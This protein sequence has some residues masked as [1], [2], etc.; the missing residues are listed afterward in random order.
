MSFERACMCEASPK[1]VT[2]LDVT[3]TSRIA[4]KSGPPPP[5]WNDRTVIP[6]RWRLSLASSMRDSAPPMPLLEL[7]TQFHSLNVWAVNL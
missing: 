4:F 7:Q 5:K 3:P 1:G 6:R 2:T